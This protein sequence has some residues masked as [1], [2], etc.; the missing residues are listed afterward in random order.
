MK[1]LLIFVVPTLF[2]IA[3]ATNDGLIHLP[4]GDPACPAGQWVNAMNPMA[5]ATP[6]AAG[7]GT[8]PAGN[9]PQIGGFS[10]ANTPEAE[11]VSGDITFNRTGANA[12]NGN[13]V[14]VNGAAVPASAKLT[15]TNASKQIVA[16][17][18][19]TAPIAVS[20]TGGISITGVAGDVLAGSGPAF[21]NSPTLG[22][23]SASS[24]GIIFARSSGANT[25]GFIASDAAVS[26]FQY[27]L[28]VAPTTNGQFML[29]NTVGGGFSGMSWGSAQGT[30]TSQSTGAE[31][32]AARWAAV[33]P[34]AGH[35]T[36]L[37]CTAVL[38]GACTTDPEYNV[39]D[40]TAATSGTATTGLTTTVGTLVSVAETL[41]FAAGD[42]I[43]IGVSTQ[44]SVC[45]APQ[46]TCTATYT[47]P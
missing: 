45:T 40:I 15:S 33:M 31:T 4:N 43:A 2:L 22:V 36:R 29:G 38:T 30:L 8:Y 39:F 5:C 17:A 21:T 20:A 28:P 41:T 19:E 27:I 6:V 9:A 46:F 1:R 32:T 47:Q 34:N 10:A 3:C 23:A 44:E 14:Q 7:S 25:I 24:G 42:T 16:A 26:S 11:T 18:A 12:Y 37:V 13:V 35:F